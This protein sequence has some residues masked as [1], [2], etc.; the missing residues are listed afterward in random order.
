MADKNDPTAPQTD[1]SEPKEYIG[2]ERI[3]TQLE[4]GK[5]EQDRPQHGDNGWFEKFAA[6]RDAER[7]SLYP[8]K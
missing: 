2:G 8:Y 1:L 7:E 4:G 3:K 5:D 6:G